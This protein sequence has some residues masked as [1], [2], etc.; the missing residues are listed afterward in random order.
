MK[1]KIHDKDLDYVLAKP[2]AKHKRPIRPN[3]FFRILMR[4]VA[5]FDLAKTHFKFEKVG[6]E[7]LGEGQNALYLM[8]H[9]SFIDLEIVARMLFPK[10]FNIITTSDA[11]VGKELLLRHIGCIPTRKFVSDPT[12]VRD[13]IYAA[14]KLHSNVVLFPEAGYSFD[15]TATT[16]PDSVGKFAKVLG[17]PVVMITTYGAFARDP[18]YNNIQVRK[19]D[20]SAKMEYIISEDDLETKSVEEL[21]SVIQKNFSFDNFRWQNQNS[22][23]ISEPFRADYLERVLYKCPFCGAEGKMVGKGIRIACEACGKAHILTEYGRLAREDGKARFDFVSDWYKWERG[24]VREEIERGEY[25]FDLPVEIMM[26]VDNK[27]IYRVG[28]GRLSHSIDGFRLTDDSGRINYEHKPLSSYSLNADF[29]WYEI[30]DIICIGNHEALYYCFPKADR[31]IV[32]K[33]RLATEEIY[34]LLT[35]QKSVESKI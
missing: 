21:N 26:A 8:N 28:E 4:A 2:R 33:A 24:C 31:G 30:G 12:L 1:I 17:L 25:G 6:M 10:P 27:R 5:S 14:K 11:F 32:A 34:K 23:R 19:V 13:A 15:G 9:S 16:I 18:L 22:V 7:K 35:E 3:M 20:V 29:N